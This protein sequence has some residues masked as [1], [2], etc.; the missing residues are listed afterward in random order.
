MR[1]IMTITLTSYVS[2]PRCGGQVTA[3]LRTHNNS[4]YRL[5]IGLFKALFG[6][7]HLDFPWKSIHHESQTFRKQITFPRK[8][9]DSELKSPKTDPCFIHRI[10]L[11]KS[12]MIN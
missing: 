4:Y 9:Q 7:A 5:D 2:F 6:L 1:I 12:Q 8:Q 3:P 10:Q 11:C